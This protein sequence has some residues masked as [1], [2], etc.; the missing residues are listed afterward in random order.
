M[1]DAQNSACAFCK[2]VVNIGE[3][4]SNILQ[5]IEKYAI[6]ADLKPACQHHNLVIPRHHKSNPK[7][8]NKKDIDLVKEMHKF[9][10]VHLNDIVEKSD[11]AE[12]PHY[13]FHFPP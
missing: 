12:D 8:L 5:S 7:T 4:N 9:G 11:N 10:M 3:G 13:R 6:L 1:V 2:L